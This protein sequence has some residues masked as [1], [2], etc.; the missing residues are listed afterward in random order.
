MP[1]ASGFRKKSG[2]EKGLLKCRKTSRRARA[3]PAS[4]TSPEGGPSGRMCPL[5]GPSPGSQGGA[6]RT[7]APP[8]QPPLA[9]PPS[10]R[11]CRSGPPSAGKPRSRLPGQQGGPH[12]REARGATRSSNSEKRAKI[13]RSYCAYPKEGNEGIRNSLKRSDSINSRK[14]N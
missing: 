4:K 3:R 7:G 2:S 8:S 13:R 10:S 14:Y 9:P 1:V 12:A 11:F 5:R 6:R